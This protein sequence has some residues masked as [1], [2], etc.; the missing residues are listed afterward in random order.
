MDRELV[1]KKPTFHRAKAGNISYRIMLWLVLLAAAS[2]LLF[3]FQRGEI[4]PRNYPTPT[5][6]RLSRS[7]IREAE[8]YFIS[9]K[10]DDPNTEN[11]AIGAYTQALEQDPSNA[12]IWAELARIKTYSSSLLSTQEQIHQRRLDA[13]EDIQKAAEL[14]PDDS[15][16][17]AVYS[18][19]LDWLATSG[20][21]TPE[22]R[23]DY[24]TDANGEAVRAIQLDPNNPLALAFYAE[25]LLDGQRWTQAED[26]AR[27]AVERGPDLMDTHRVY[28][29]VLESIGAYRDA[30][31]QYQLAAE[32]NPNLTFLFIQI[33]V[34]YRHLAGNNPDSPLYQEA[35]I[36][37]EKAA[38]INNQIG[39]KDP[40][41]YIAIAKTYSQLGEFFVASRNAEKALA[42]NPNDANTYGQL[43]IIYFKS[44]NY[45]GALV[46]LQCAV[47]GC[48]LDENIVLDE[49]AKENPDWGVEPL[50]IKG[51]PLDSLEVAYYYVM[52][53]QA[54][55]YLSRPSNQY[56][57]EAFPVLEMVRDKYSQDVVL[58]EVVDQSIAICRQ[59]EG[60]SSP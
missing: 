9:G 52:Y 56:C 24:L 22:E 17:H 51:L 3:R 8:A 43:G 55:A 54:L 23:D 12:Q 35:L 40:L 19:V 50:A 37:F 49:I 34:T 29:T 42:F 57:E 39:V 2:F 25:I 18:F 10:I 47:A 45:E 30:I 36:N 27:Q 6:T 13:L 31:E 15:G 32:I 44:K 20:R 59:V 26:Y 58:M 33:G 28:G 4:K 21:V 53:G 7:Y 60:G 41:P 14:A 1:G 48:T 38:N 46:A 5:A 16:V 11:D